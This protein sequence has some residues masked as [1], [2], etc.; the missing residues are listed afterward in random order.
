[1]LQRTGCCW[2]SGSS[3]QHHVILVQLREHRRDLPLPVGVVE[4]LVDG[5]RRDAQR[6]MRCRGR[7]PASPAAPAPA[8]RWP[9]REA[10]AIAAACPACAGI[11]VQFVRIRIFQRVL[12]LR[13]A[14]A[15][16]HR[17]VLHRLHEERD[18]RH[19]G[20]LPAAAAGS[21]RWRSI[22]RSSSGFRLIR[23]RPL[24]RV[25]LVPSMPMN[26]D[27]LSTAGSFRMIFGQRLLQL[28][29]SWKRN[30]LRGFGDALN[31]AGIL[32]R[33]R[34]PWGCAMNRKIG[35]C[36]RARRPPAASLVW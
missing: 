29:M 18:A 13:A 7:K 10:P 12:E 20:Q 34:S 19:F 16:F 22:L 9:R 6:A 8:D 26:D 24:F 33:E 31:H 30:R 36:Q 32:D 25:V 14:D 27:R 28:D 17:E 35:Q 1:M 5:G 4:R 11:D 15:V 23:M 3:F 21:P 2:N